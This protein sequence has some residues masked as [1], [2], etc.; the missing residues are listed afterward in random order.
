MITTGTAV[1]KPWYE[2]VGEPEPPEDGRQQNRTMAD[3]TTVLRARY[4]QDEETVLISGPT[5]ILYD[6][7]NPNARIAPDCYVVFNVDA[8][9]IET[10]NAYRIWQWGKPPDFVLEVA[11][12]S[13]APCDLNDKRTRYESMGVREYWRFDP[14]GG[15][16]YG[17]PLIAERLVDSVYVPIPTHTELNGDVW[18]HSEVLDIDFY[19]RDELFW[20]KD[21]PTGKWLNTL[22]AELAAHEATRAAHEVTNAAHQQEIARR[23]AAESQVQELQAEIERLRVE[24]SD[25]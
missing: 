11:S 12:P 25:Q 9:M 4:R 1:A 18:A 19:W 6:R 3:I 16:L 5:F 2:T 21:T 15:E 8:T 7:D 23:I 20:A 13:T 17:E 24:H 22:E 10:H 14:S